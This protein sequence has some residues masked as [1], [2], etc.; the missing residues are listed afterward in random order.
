M[1]CKLA[2]SCR[3]RRFTV[4][5]SCIFAGNR[6]SSQL[7]VRAATVARTQPPLAKL[8]PINIRLQRAHGSKVVSAA[9]AA[10]QPAAGSIGSPMQGTL[11]S[12]GITPSASKRAELTA[13][14]AAGAAAVTA[15][16][17]HDM[18]QG[19]AAQHQQPAE[20]LVSLGLTRIAAAWMLQDVPEIASLKPGEVQARVEALR[21]AFGG[22]L[23]AAML[24]RRLARMPKLLTLA[25]DDIAAAHPRLAEYCLTADEAAAALVAQPGILLTSRAA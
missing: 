20:F 22:S 23:P 18:P 16:V 8:T 24:L 5:Q 17:S 13:P 10:K 11:Q 19:D 6:T 14:A 21:A 15:D 4:Q 9:S 3:G 12:L 7:P 2:C 25:V 1:R